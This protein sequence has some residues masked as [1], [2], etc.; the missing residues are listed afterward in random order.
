[1]DP[2][3]LANHFKWSNYDEPIANEFCVLDYVYEVLREIHESEICDEVL[4]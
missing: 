1:M 2:H 4:K 3:P